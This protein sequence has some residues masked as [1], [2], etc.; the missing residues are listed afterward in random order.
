MS[1]QVFAA[2]QMLTL[3]NATLDTIT[4]SGPR[5]SVTVTASG[6][7]NSSGITQTNGFSSTSNLY[8]VQVALA[9]GNAVVRGTNA[10]SNVQ[11]S[12]SVTNPG[13][14]PFS[15]S[16]Q[17]TVQGLGISVSFGFG[18]AINAF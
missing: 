14:F 13:R 8:P 4:G 11:A 3:D 17:G 15:H 6:S 12:S 1:T 2:D 9:S 16:I 5:A 7:G 18:A 10:S